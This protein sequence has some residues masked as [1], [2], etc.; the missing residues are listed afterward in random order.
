MCS[1]ASSGFLSGVEGLRGTEDELRPG[2]V[3]D[4]PVCVPVSAPESAPAQVVRNTRWNAPCSAIGITSGTD[5][6]TGGVSNL[7]PWAA[8]ILFAVIATIAAWWQ[9]C[10]DR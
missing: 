5:G 1:R 3:R 7:M 6:F 4:G 2:E 10:T 9:G 8:F